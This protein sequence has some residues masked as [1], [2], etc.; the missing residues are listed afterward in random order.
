MPLNILF[1]ADTTSEGTY[2]ASAVLY[3]HAEAEIKENGH[4]SD[5]GRM[6][7]MSITR[8][9]NI[10]DND[11]I[12]SYMI[13]CG[14]PAYVSDKYLN[15]NSYANSD[16]LVNTIRLTGREKIVADIDLKVLDDTSLDITTSQSNTWTV[17][18]AAVI[19]LIIGVVGIVVCKRRRAK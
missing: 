17:V 1:D 13:V 12:Y 9:E 8:R 15:S 2:R 6:P 11:F 3:S 19:P 16:I 5:G 10:K 14:S 18:F 4:T 7:L